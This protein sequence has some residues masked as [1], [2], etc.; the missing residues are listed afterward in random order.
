M[1]AFSR[2]CGALHL[3]ASH[4]LAILEW[5]MWLNVFGCYLTFQFVLTK[6]ALLGR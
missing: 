5:E 6:Q 1:P 2:G 4:R 3:A